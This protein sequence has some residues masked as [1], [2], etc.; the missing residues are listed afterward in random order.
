LNSPSHHQPDTPEI[1]PQE[2]L[3]PVHFGDIPPPLPP[4]APPPRKPL[5][6]MHLLLGLILVGGILL[7]WGQLGAQSLW[8]DEGMTA[9]LVTVPLGEMVAFMRQDASFPLLFVLLKPWVALF[10]DSEMAL[11]GFSALMATIAMGVF[12]RLCLGLLI[13]PAAVVGSMLLMAVSVTQIQYAR[14]ARYYALLSLL[15]LIMLDAVR[16]W[17]TNRS[18]IAMAVLIFCGAAS[19]YTHQISIVH[20]AVLNLGWL[21]MPGNVAFRDRIWPI[22]LSNVAMAVL[23]LPWL[24]VV[25]EQVRW[26]RASFWV[27]VPDRF[28]LLHSLAVITGLKPIAL[29][30][31][32]GARPALSVDAHVWAGVAMV[33]LVITSVLALVARPRVAGAML[34]VALLPVIGLYLYSHL[35]QPLFLERLFVPAS[36]LVALLA[37]AMLTRRFT[38]FVGWPLVV[39]LI[40]LSILSIIAFERY[41]QKEQWRQAFAH[42]QAMPRDRARLMIFV[43]AEG[44]VVFDYYARRLASDPPWD[45]ATGAPQ[46]FF[47][48]HPPQV[49]MRVNDIRDLLPMRR[50]IARGR[51]QEVVLVLSHEWHADPQGVVTRYLRREWGIP[52]ARDFVGV[53]VHRYTRQFS[54]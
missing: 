32:G 26:V 11:R 4:P 33:L 35:G 5:P 45:D 39:V 23:F 18:R 24:G 6:W 30:S 12:Y 51:F 50:A 34:I 41:E 7:R 53:S 44:Q 29:A 22:I 28:D 52:Q 1:S 27:E 10:G 38:A 8:L 20:I 14:E 13:Q 54:S 25:I 3:P 17:L 46:G 47:D 40:H 19:L 31:L 48:S 16:T 36:P 9:W 37:G 43:T 21:A 15:L 42:V 2:P 49:L